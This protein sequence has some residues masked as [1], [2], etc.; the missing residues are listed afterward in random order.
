MRMIQIDKLPR[1]GLF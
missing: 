1:S